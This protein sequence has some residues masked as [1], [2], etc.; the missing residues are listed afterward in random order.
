MSSPSV[1]ALIFSLFLILSSA[2]AFNITKILSNTTDL[3]TFSNYL[4]QT[5]VAS[6]INGHQTITVLAVPNDAIS[7][8]SGLSQDAIKKSLSAHVMLDYY[9]EDKLKSLHTKSVTVT[10]LFQQSGQAQ[11]NQGYVNVSRSGNGPVVFKSA[12]RG[13][14]QEATLVKTIIA[15]PYNISVLQITNVIYIASNSTTPASPPAPVPTASAPRKALAPSP[16]KSSPAASP[17][18]L[19]DANAPSADSL[20]GSPSN[21]VAD[22]PGGAGNKSSAVSVITSGSYLLSA[23]LMILASAWFMI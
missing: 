20:S 4:T 7:A 23:I 1:S 12:A 6:E 13:S 19:S 5:G 22:G 21:S 11:N 9:D 18:S 15:Q 2:D 10:T 3:S 14:N 17:P 8:L 16:R